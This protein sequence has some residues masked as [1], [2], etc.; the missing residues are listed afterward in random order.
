[1]SDVTLWTLYQEGV[2]Y[3]RKMGFSTNFPTYVKYIKLQMKIFLR[4]NHKNH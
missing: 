1:M 2:A 4:I 3:Q